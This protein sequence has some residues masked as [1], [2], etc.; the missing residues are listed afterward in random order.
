VKGGMWSAIKGERTEGG[1]FPLEQ[2]RAWA[3][4]GQDAA[5]R[6][7]EAEERQPATIN[8]V[9]YNTGSQI[10]APDTRG[11]AGIWALAARNKTPFGG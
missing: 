8:I 6:A 3:E 7:L 9:T 5:R 10:N 4:Q 2:L 11:R 1:T